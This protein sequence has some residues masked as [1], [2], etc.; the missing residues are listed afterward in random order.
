[1]VGFILRPAIASIRSIDFD[2][3]SIRIVVCNIDTE[4]LNITRVEN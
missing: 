4:N 2:T 1:M 3:D